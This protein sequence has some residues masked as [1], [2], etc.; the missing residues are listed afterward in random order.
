VPADHPHSVLIVEDDSDIRHSIAR[1]IE[2]EGYLVMT[3]RNGA[4]AIEVLKR[5]RPCIVLLDLMMPIMDGWQVVGV[6]SADEFLKSIPVVVTS[7]FAAHAPL[8]PP[9]ARVLSKPLDT[10]KLLAAIEAFC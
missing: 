7:A 10:A 9:V 6:M 3:A 8:E 5:A 4:E 2:D 1:L